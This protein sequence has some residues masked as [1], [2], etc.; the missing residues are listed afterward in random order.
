[1]VIVLSG[2]LDLWE[3]ASAYFLCEKRSQRIVL[4][5]WLSTGLSLAGLT[6]SEKVYIVGHFDMM[7]LCPNDREGISANALATALVAAGLP[8]VAKIVL[9]ACDTANSL[10]PGLETG[11]F[12]PYPQVLKQAIALHSPGKLSIPVVGYRSG[13]NVAPGGR[14][15]VW[16]AEDSSG[17]ATVETG[18]SAAAQ[19]LQGFLDKQK[20]PANADGLQDILKQL[21]ALPEW[22]A[23]CQEIAGDLKTLETDKLVIPKNPP[24]ARKAVY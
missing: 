13:V 2:K 12:G 17:Q 4:L 3:V 21:T 5:P 18:E 23:Y 9:V 7:Q 14:R 22:K 11:Q 24:E 8:A 6:A 19:A 16:N 20:P 1:M 10:V 15:Y